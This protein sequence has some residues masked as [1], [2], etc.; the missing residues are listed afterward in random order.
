MHSPSTKC[1][2]Y[3]CIFSLQPVKEDVI[4]SVN[5]SKLIKQENEEASEIDVVTS[6]GKSDDRRESGNLNMLIKQ[7]IEET[8][9][10]ETL[11]S[12]RKSDGRRGRERRAKY[13]VKTKADVVKECEAGK[14]HEFLARKYGINR[15]LVRKLLLW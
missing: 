9:E 5:G 12:R 13:S 4:K 6:K 15:C 8:S 2:C 11:E 7:E 14:S 1:I 10:N 3:F